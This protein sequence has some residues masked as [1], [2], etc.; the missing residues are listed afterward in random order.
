MNKTNTQL[1]EWHC[2][3]AKNIPVGRLATQISNLL[4]G[5]GKVTF[6]PNVDGGD[7]VVVI[8]VDNIALTGNK[9]ADKKYYSHSGYPGNLR[10]RQISDVGLS[11]VLERAVFGMLPK[12]KLHPLWMKRLHI[13]PG[14]DHPHQANL[15]NKS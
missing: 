8:N 14:S 10:T 15:A 3:D 7:H 5:K 12:N 2:L 1:H 9:L 4:R 11:N 13:Y 6:R